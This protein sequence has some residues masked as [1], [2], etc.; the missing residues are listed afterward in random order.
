GAHL[1][2]GAGH[3]STGSPVV[4]TALIRPRVVVVGAGIAWGDNLAKTGKLFVIHVDARVDDG[5]RDA[6]PLRQGMRCFYVGTGIDLLAVDRG[7]FEVPLLRGNRAASK[8]SQH[9]RG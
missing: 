4:F 5:N 6:F 7:R 8:P 1:A 3:A 9:I 2:I